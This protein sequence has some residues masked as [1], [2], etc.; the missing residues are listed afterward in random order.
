VWANGLPTKFPELRGAM[1]LILVDMRCYLDHGGTICDCQQIADGW[2]G[3]T[4]NQARWAYRWEIAPGRPPITGL[5]EEG[6][7]LPAGRLIQERIHFLGFVS[8]REYREGE[9]RNIGYYLANWHLFS[10]DS[11]AREVFASY[12][13]QPSSS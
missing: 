12:P 6:N 9:I 7:P 2:F 11:Q 13:L 10:D 3:L 5:F 8:E 1:H 4:F